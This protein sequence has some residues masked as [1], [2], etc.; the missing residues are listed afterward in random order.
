MKTRLFDDCL[1]GEVGLGCWQIGGSWGHVSDSDAIGILRTAYENGVTFFD[2]ADV[3]GGGRSEDLISQWVRMDHPR[4]ILVATKQG[5]A[6]EPGWPENFTLAAMRSHVDASRRRLGVDSLDLLQLHCIPEAALREGSVF[7]HLRILQEEGA[8]RRFGASV[9]SMEQ[10]AICMQH[11]DLVSLQILFNVFRQRPVWQLF[12]KAQ[13]Q[14]TAIIVRLPL[15]SGL[16]TGKMSTMTVF[17][18]TDHRN[19]N[20]DGAAF[21][22]G[23]TFSGLPFIDGLDLVDALLPFVP[24]DM[25]LSQFAM[26]WIL[27]HAAVT[28][29]IP[30]ASRADQIVG[31]VSAGELSPLP[32]E[33]HASLEAWYLTYV[34]AKVRGPY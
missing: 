11:A 31:N 5:R 28:V 2:T 23:E 18:A 34:D 21:N 4:G 15:A 27:D 24:G 25:S 7:D 17:D 16:L 3:Y 22:V 29:V 32:S 10:A 30:G 12:D 9:E 1:V 33:L 14:G 6:S 13:A 19:F 8:I 20:R 26:R